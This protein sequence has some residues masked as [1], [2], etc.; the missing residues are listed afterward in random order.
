MSEYTPPMDSRAKEYDKPLSYAFAI[1]VA[2]E[3]VEEWSYED[4]PH[5]YCHLRPVLIALIKGENE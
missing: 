5:G 1:E 3:L 4:D 2:K